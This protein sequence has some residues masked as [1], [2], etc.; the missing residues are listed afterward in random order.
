MK[1][2]NVA[3]RDETGYY[4]S[5]F[6]TWHEAN[7]LLS[8]AKAHDPY[9]HIVEREVMT[10]V[11]RL[12]AELEEERTHHQHTLECAR[13]FEAEWASMKRERDALMEDFDKYRIRNIQ[14]T[15]GVYAC[16]LCKYGGD[17]YRD[18]VGKKCPKGCDGMTKWKWRGLCA[19]NGGTE[20]A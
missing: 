7:D 19:E 4:S 2:Y 11:E 1:R 10:E 20:D 9:A 3:N 18:E 6:D 8:L 16:D 14:Q 12:Q 13:Q 17:P 5:G 15:S